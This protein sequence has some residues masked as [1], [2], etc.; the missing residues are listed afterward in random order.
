MTKTAT[1]RKIITRSSANI[2][3]T[4]KAKRAKSSKNA[5]TTEAKNDA[6][7]KMLQHLDC[8]LGHNKACVSKT[9]QKCIYNPLYLATS[10]QQEICEIL[11]MEK[12][13]SDEWT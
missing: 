4:P 11:E 13:T 12:K 10:K 2:E 6:Q 9:L 3:E 5:K 7:T 8:P 1:T